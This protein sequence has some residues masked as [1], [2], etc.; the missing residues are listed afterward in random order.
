MTHEKDREATLPHVASCSGGRA[1]T[2]SFRGRRPR[3][4]GLARI[5]SER[6]HQLARWS[7]EHDDRHVRGELVEAAQQLLTAVQDDLERTPAGVA[8]WGLVERHPD[9]IERLAIAGAL[10][11]AELDR[12]LRCEHQRGERAAE[13]LGTVT[14]DGGA[15]PGRSYWIVEGLCEALGHQA[16]PV[17]FGHGFAIPLVG[18]LDWTFAAD[19]E[20]ATR[21]SSI[22]T[23][24]R[25]MERMRQGRSRFGQ[26]AADGTRTH[27]VTADYTFRAV[28]I[29]E[30][31]PASSADGEPFHLQAPL[32]AWAD[33]DLRAH[34]A[35]Q[36][37]WSA[38]TFG[39]GDRR[40]ALC[41]HIRKELAEVLASDGA[42]EEWIDVV[43]LGL[44]GAWRS[45]ASPEQIIVA[46][47]EK[48]AKNLA[49]TWPDWRTV[50]ADQ[51]IEHVRQA[52]APA[53][54]PAAQP[55]PLAP[56]G[57]ARETAL[58]DDRPHI[59]AGLRIEE[60]PA[61]GLDGP[62]Q[63]S[64][65]YHIASWPSGTTLERGRALSIESL[66]RAMEQSWGGRGV[67]LL[68][69]R[70]SGLRQQIGG[71]VY[72]LAPQVLGVDLLPPTCSAWAWQRK[73]G[74]PTIAVTRRPASN[75][76]LEEQLAELAHCVWTGQGELDFD[77]DAVADRPEYGARFQLWAAVNRYAQACGGDTSDASVGGA[78]MDAVAAVDR[79][80]TARKLFRI[81]DVDRPMH[82]VAHDWQD[83]I[84][85]WRRELE[86]S[87]S[88]ADPSG[89]ELV[90]NSSDLRIEGEEVDRG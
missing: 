9:P 73:M 68:I 88:S 62:P 26:V 11:A 34:L 82:V 4:S 7:A 89:V 32:P 44:D 46:L 28:E 10:I 21:F 33:F 37:E 60:G 66:R 71:E 5:V 18:D 16:S 63:L 86:E 77:W 1:P 74:E 69:V 64:W 76:P 6:Q 87:D 80:V 8:D 2:A 3:P 45:G 72:G 24:A 48:Q 70:G 83:A 81:Q 57:E 58:P 67:E 30:K 40:T 29:R 22:E 75:F 19:R 79:A 39:P 85:V 31:V 61:R 56:D 43:I 25:A 51:P 53:P 20:H 35:E 50:P 12:R 14:R 84:R 38:R 54:A 15:T 78:R 23:A 36:V 49:R 27:R 59:T 41:E 42:L 47:K 52:P 90:C 17:V 55:E 65:H 13:L